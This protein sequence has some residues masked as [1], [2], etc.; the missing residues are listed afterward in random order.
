MRTAA[1]LSGSAWDLDRQRTIAASHR[2][3]SCHPGLMAVT[4]PE[5]LPT[6]EAAL[7]AANWTGERVSESKLRRQSHKRANVAHGCLYCDPMHRIDWL[8]NPR[9]SQTLE[10]N[11][12][13]K[14]SRNRAMCVLN[15]F[16]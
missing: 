14:R 1:T 10:K 12:A 15:G 16:A 6:A 8:G 13:M 3:L 5:S 7:D 9:G 4:P 11:A 2:A